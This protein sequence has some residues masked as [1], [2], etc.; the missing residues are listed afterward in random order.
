MSI[1]LEKF[2]CFGIDQKQEEH[3]MGSLPKNC[4]QCLEYLNS[5]R[6]LVETSKVFSTEKNT[7]VLDKENNRAQGSTMA[8]R[9]IEMVSKV[10]ELS[11]EHLFMYVKRFEGIAAQFSIMYHTRIVKERVPDPKNM[12]NA[13]A[14][15]DAVSEQKLSQRPKKE[16]K[17][18]SDL[19]K[20]ISI[21]TSVG[22]PYEAA[23]TEVE[24]RFKEQGKVIS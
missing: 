23:K 11:L 14:F 18:L 1:T 5:C 21:L 16:K 15:S 19:E 22:V 4:E 13:K 8:T 9:H 7:F 20:S 12:E 3:E 10:H 6:L 17:M 24:K 2:S